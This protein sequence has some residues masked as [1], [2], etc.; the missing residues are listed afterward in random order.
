MNL[1]KN[2]ASEKVKPPGLSSRVTLKR[3]AFRSN[4]AEGHAKSVMVILQKLVH[5]QVR[6][7][8]L[9]KSI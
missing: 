8:T 4:D 2:F 5:R 7:V 1:H 9:S 6:K 3:D